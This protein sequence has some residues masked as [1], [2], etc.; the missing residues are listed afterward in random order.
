MTPVDKNMEPL[1]AILRHAMRSEPGPATPECADTESLAAYSDRSLSARERERLETHFA[2]CARCQLLLADIARADESARIA[3]S[4]GAVPWYRRWRLAI[5]A[6]AAAA[7]VLV[8]VSIRRPANVAPPND[9]IVAMAQHEAPAA[10]LAAKQPPLPA[11][12]PAAAPSA[13]V[14]VAAAAPSN[15]IAMNELKAEAAPRAQAMRPS[16]PRALKGSV[17]AFGAGALMARGA[18]AANVATQPPATTTLESDAEQASS[19]DSVP[20]AAVV[21]AAPQTTARSAA[22]GGML[23]EPAAAT[24]TRAFGSLASG[25]G[26]IV[27]ATRGGGAVGAVAGAAV[28]A[29]VAASPSYA[30]ASATLVTI[31]AP[32]QSVSW[33]A[34]K[35]GMILRR[36][37]D[38]STHPQHSG[39]S[40]DLIA[41][42]APSATV[43]WIVGRSGTIVRTTDGGEHWTLILGPTADNLAAV[44]ASDA[45]DATVTTAGGRSFATSD[46][47]ASWHPQ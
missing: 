45:N 29:T 37:A 11:P 35:N 32:D 6:L 27:A 28:G 24:N 34:G 8:F 41:G 31:S 25:S 44:T 36:D 1:D 9:Q 13:P 14:S 38:G 26:A 22:V 17:E 42:A 33:I 39:A 21:A 12:V 19:A 7:A 47:G 4:A 23:A 30:P 46:G 20:R 3:K 2:D 40:T 5:P 18:P 43:C 15:E 16:A 10:N